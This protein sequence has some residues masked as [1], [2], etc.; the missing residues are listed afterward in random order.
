VVAHR[1]ST[2]KNAD[3]IIMLDG[4]YICEQGTHDELMAM[5]NGRYREL[6]LKHKGVGVIE[7]ENDV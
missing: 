6:Y 3:R 5:E 4:G 7:D 2:I 1:L